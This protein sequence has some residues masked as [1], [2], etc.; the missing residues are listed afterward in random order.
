VPGNV[1]V[2]SLRANLLRKDA[3]GEEMLG[4]SNFYLFNPLEEGEE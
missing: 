2:V 1:K 3:S 4:L